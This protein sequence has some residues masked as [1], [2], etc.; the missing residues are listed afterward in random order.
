LKGALLA[1]PG[2]GDEKWTTGELAQGVK[3]RYLPKVRLFARGIMT[4]LGILHESG[5]PE[6][7]I[8]TMDCH[9]TRTAILD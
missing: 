3:E 9:P 6:P 5:H 1:D 4:N 2:Y 7:W 8:I